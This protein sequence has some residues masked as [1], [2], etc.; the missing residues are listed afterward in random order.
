MNTKYLFPNY[1][2]LA[3]DEDTL[4]PLKELEGDIEFER[5]FEIWSELHEKWAFSDLEEFANEYY[6]KTRMN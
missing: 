3:F 1:D 2:I 4:N 6:A 5:S